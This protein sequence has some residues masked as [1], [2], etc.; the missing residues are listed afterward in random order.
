[1]SGKE[2]IV[3]EPSVALNVLWYTKKIG[4]VAS[5]VIHKD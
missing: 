4:E 2:E 5:E 3:P 1:M